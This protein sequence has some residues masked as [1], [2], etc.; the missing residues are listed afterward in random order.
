MTLEHISYSQVNTYRQC[1]RSWYLGRLKGAESKQTWYTAIGSAT[2]L[3]IE[4]WLKADRP[5]PEDFPSAE[6]FLYPILRSQM[7][8]QPDLRQWMAGGPKADPTVGVKAVELVRVCFERAV[9]VLESVEVLGVEVDLTGSLPG[10]PVPIKAFADI[11]GIHKKTKR[12]VIL[13]W[14]TG[15]A[16]PKDGFQLETYAALLEAH[17]RW[18]RGDG[19][20]GYYIMLNPAARK[21]P[22]GKPIDL[23]HVIPGQIGALY[24]EVY[25]QMQKRDY[26]VKSGSSCFNCFVQESC[27]DRSGPTPQA[28]YY[29]HGDEEGFPF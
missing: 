20:D 24:G 7:K 29:D 6:F 5:S 23:D 4:E 3:M 9:K 11:I 1:P 27:L 16:K 18:L 2:H 21:D 10:C 28:V 13:D 17:P 8:I 15:M 19:V 26:R 14:K 12:L 25:A 22:W